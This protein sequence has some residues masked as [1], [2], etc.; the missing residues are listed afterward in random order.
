MNT[1]IAILEN[2]AQ[3]R[4]YLNQKNFSKEFVPITLSF[5]AEEF[6]RKNNIQVKTEEDYEKEGLYR[7]LHEESMKLTWKICKNIKFKY[8]GKFKVNRFDR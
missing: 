1:K 5:E 2:E 6:F 4:E 8:D 3:A 7:N